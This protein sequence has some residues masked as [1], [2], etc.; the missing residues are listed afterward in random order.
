MKNY[1]E[2]LTEQI[3]VENTLQSFT[4]IYDMIVVTIEESKD[5]ETMKMEG[6]QGSLEARELRLNQRET[7][8]YSE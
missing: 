7:N 2:T 6:L 8:K 5:L 3:K 4:P 1:G